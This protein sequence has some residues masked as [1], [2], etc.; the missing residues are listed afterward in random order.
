MN[1]ERT[2]MRMSYQGLLQRYIH[3]YIISIH[4]I[5]IAVLDM[6]TFK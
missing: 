4:P 5:R 6:H 1:S 2:R 3:S